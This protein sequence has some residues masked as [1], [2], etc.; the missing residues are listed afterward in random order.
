LRDDFS[1]SYNL[2]LLWQPRNWFSLGL[3]YQSE[4]RVEQTG[5]Y[6]V[7]HSPRFSAM[8]DWMRQGM[9]LP[10]A[11]S[12][13]NLPTNGE[14]QYGYCS[15]TSLNYPQRIQSGIKLQPVKE[16]KI[17][18][19]VH[20]AQWSIL[21]EDRFVFDQNISFL[22]LTNIMGYGEQPNVMV[23]KRNFKDTIHWSAA[24]EYLPTDWL[25]MRLGYEMR[26][27]SVRA[28]LYDGL[29]SLP[30]LHNIGTGLGFKLDN[31]L[32][33]NLAFA[34]LFNKSYSVPNGSSIQMNSND[35]TKP[36]YNPFVGLNYFQETRAYMFSG[37][38]SMPL[39]SISKMTKDGIKSV[40][41]VMNML[42]P[43]N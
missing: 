40:K 30:D 15:S 13:L 39:E 38:A 16:F 42:N 20:W 23:L 31:G 9:V 26:P 22:R 11:A 25:T 29:Y 27:T 2:G 33:L 8:M 3:C 7:Q 14:D 35:W 5:R 37:S 21:K 1:P 32:E 19:D 34:Y 17:L 28:E 18:G 4:I 6:S 12:M 10:V 24:V 43:F 36:V 41:K